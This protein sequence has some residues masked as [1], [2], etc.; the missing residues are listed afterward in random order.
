MEVS[1]SLLVNSATAA[2]MLSVCSKTL[3]SLTARGEIPVV[4]VGRAVRYSP[5]DLRAW[6]ATKRGAK[7]PAA[8]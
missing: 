5:D 6:I 4:Q 8:A 2:R 3:W 7:T 1:E